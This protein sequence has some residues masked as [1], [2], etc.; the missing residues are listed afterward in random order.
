[1]HEA[2]I[3]NKTGVGGIGLV[4]GASSLFL[5]GLTGIWGGGDVCELQVV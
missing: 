3:S 1:M 2:T 5:T 4:C